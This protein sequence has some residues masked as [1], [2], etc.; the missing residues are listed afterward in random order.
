MPKFSTK[1]QKDEPIASVVL[2]AAETP[3]FGDC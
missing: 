1:S 3:N 2:L